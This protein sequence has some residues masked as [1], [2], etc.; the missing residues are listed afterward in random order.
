MSAQTITWELPDQTELQNV[1]VWLGSPGFPGPQP[2]AVDNTTVSFNI[3]TAIPEGT[4]LHYEIFGYYT[5]DKIRRLIKAGDLVANVNPS[6]ATNLQITFPPRKPML[7]TIGGISIRSQWSDDFAGVP[8]GQYI[9]PYTGNGV[10]YNAWYADFLYGTHQ[11]DPLKCTVS[12]TEIAIGQYIPEIL[13]FT[14]GFPDGQIFDL[15][16]DFI[17][18]DQTGTNWLTVDQGESYYYGGT[19]HIQEYTPPTPP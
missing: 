16:E 8:A 7:V 15:A 3:D 18:L 14:P 2:N 12:M 1:I 19:M 5:V 9:L 13:I 4:K 10:D 11:G 17:E 6:P